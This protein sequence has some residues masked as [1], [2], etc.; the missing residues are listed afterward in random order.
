M[1]NLLAGFKTIIL[2]LRTVFDLAK[3]YFPDARFSDQLTA[4][5]PSKG[6]KIKPKQHWE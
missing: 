6:V 3:H 5:G 4:L 2:I 1:K